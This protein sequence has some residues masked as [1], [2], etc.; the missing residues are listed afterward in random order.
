ME[1]PDTIGRILRIVK[2]V[3][4]LNIAEN[5]E[6]GATKKFGKLSKFPELGLNFTPH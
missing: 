3:L 5:I 4:G 2:D 1:H 6:G